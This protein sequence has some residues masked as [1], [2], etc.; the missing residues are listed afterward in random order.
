M[1]LTLLYW[2]VIAVMLVGV[3]GAIIPGLPGTSFILLAIAVWYVATGFA[4]I[5]WPLVAIF[6][7]LILSGVVDFLATYW[8]PQRLGASKWAQYGAIAG[9]VFGIFGLLP[10]LPLGGPLLG[11]LLGPIFGAFLGEFFYRRETKLNERV[12]LSFK[13]CLGVIV[14]SIIG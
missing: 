9:L 2:L 10:A 13:A 6:S 7:I 12:K 3:V 1:N 11:I 4:G 5:G 14:G 8:G